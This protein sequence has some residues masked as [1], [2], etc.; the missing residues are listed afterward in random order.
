VFA[1]LVFAI[2]IG[3][4]PGDLSATGGGRLGV[5]A[6]L[7]DGGPSQELHGGERFPMQSVYKLPIAMAVLDQVDHKQLTLGQK[8]TLR[9]SDVADVHFHSPLRKRYPRG[10]IDVSVRELIRAAI[11][12]SDGVASDLLYRLA[13]GGPRV[14]AYLRGLG[15][16]DMAVVATEREMARDPQVQYRNFSTPCAAVSL[17]QALDTGRALSSDGRAL[18]L[19]DLTDS[20]PGARRIKGGLPPGTPVAH[21]TGTDATRHGVTRATNDIG[22]ITLPDG[23]HLAL[24]VFVKDSTADEPTRERTIADAARA[25][26]DA[27]TRR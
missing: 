10:G 16:R 18:L 2:I 25:A 5:C 13:G 4:P 7:T 9:A 14:T 6:R 17:L 22:I 3:Q 12:D 23:R 8:V 19:K 21:K 1:A 15:I 11:V 24:A 26:Y 20:V 27:W